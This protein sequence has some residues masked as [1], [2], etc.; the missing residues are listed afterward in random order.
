MNARRL[1]GP[2]RD[3]LAALRSGDDR[4]AGNT[5]LAMLDFPADEVLGWFCATIMIAAHGMDDSVLEQLTSRHLPDSGLIA[6]V[7][8]AIVGGDPDALV[9]LAPGDQVDLVFLLAA[10]ASVV[11]AH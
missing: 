9:A 10:T 6:A 7:V 5:L 3:V 11:D 1:D 2:G 4:V 8:D